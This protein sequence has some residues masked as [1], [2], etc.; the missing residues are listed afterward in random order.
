MAASGVG[1]RV[2]LGEHAER[3]TEATLEGLP[4]GTAQIGFYS[5]GEIALDATGQCALHHHTM[6][7]TV[8]SEMA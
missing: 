8:L 6:T 5:S 2:V 3:E 1:R 4:V 7:L